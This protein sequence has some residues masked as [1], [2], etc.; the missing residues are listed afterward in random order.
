MSGDNEELI[1]RDFAEG[2]DFYNVSITLE[3]V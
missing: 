1:R 2:Y 3:E